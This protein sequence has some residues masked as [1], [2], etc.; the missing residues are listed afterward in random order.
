MTRLVHIDG[1]ARGAFCGWTVEGRL[2]SLSHE[3]RE[4]F[5]KNRGKMAAIIR[6]T[7]DSVRVYSEPL[8]YLIQFVQR[9]EVNA[10]LPALICVLLPIGK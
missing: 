8:T 3:E 4:L 6:R 9:E 7:S 2:E 10:W 1:C 5:C